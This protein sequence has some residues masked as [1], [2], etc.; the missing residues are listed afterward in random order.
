MQK[1][2][3]EKK[4]GN[5]RVLK[6]RAWDGKKMHNEIAL[7]CEGKAIRNGY[8]WFSAENTIYHSPVMQYT[9]LK[10]KNGVEIYSGDIV[11]KTHNKHYWVGVIECSSEQF[12]NALFY[13][14]RFSNC[15]EDEE[16]GIWTWEIIKYRNRD[17][18]PSGKNCEVIGNIYENPELLGA[19]K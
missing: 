1:Q 8:Q 15:G 16:K 3:G 18:V 14:G 11:K 19:E 13:M 9:G 12:G 6:F 4:M 7:D 2:E 17:Y 10:D 5:S